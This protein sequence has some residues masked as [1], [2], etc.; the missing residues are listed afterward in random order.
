M[1]LQGVEMAG[2]LQAGDQAALRA[3]RRHFDDKRVGIEQHV[4]SPSRRAWATLEG[5]PSDMSA[6]GAAPAP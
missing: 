3:T 4:A 5:D 2:S 1:S 6:W